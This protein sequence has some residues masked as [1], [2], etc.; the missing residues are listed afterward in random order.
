MALEKGYAT[1]LNMAKYGYFLPLELVQC[2]MKGLFASLVSCR[3]V[4]I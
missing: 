1:L 4:L 2:N 3:C